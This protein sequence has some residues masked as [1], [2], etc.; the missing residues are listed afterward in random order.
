MAVE[1]GRVTHTEN[2]LELSLKLQVF[3]EKLNCK[4]K[5]KIF[6]TTSTTRHYTLM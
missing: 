5:L 4:F 6:A 3:E 2:V 1:V